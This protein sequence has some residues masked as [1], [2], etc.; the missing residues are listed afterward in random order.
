[1]KWYLVTMFTIPVLDLFDRWFERHATRIP[2]S[3]HCVRA[4]KWFDFGLMEDEDGRWRHF[5]HLKLPSYDWGYLDYR[6][7]QG[8]LQRVVWWRAGSGFHLDLW[9]VEEAA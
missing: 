6:R 7:K 9:S 3:C 1:M 2:Q 4:D 8:W 5:F